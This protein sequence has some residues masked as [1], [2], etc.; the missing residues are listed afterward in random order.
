MQRLMPEIVPRL[1]YLLKKELAILELIMPII[2]NYGLMVK[3]L[4]L[5]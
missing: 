4:N 2:L 5:I 1:D 3:I